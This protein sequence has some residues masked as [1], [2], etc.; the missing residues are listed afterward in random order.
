MVDEKLRVCTACGTA[1]PEKDY[2]VWLT[3]AEAKRY[4]YT[5]ERRV[6]VERSRCGDCRPKK[7]PLG[8]L[9][10]K[11][12]HK[13]VL[14]GDVHT[15]VAEAVIA[16]K[17]ANALEKQTNAQYKR[18]AAVKEKPWRDVL[19]SLAIELRTNQQRLTY[20]KK[21]ADPSP[22]LLA[23]LTRYTELLI[24]KREQMKTERFKLSRA[25]ETW[26]EYFSSSERHE[27]WQMWR[28]TPMV[29]RV[30]GGVPKLWD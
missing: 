13:R 19:A 24:V 20:A 11:Q 29:H 12:I 4:G 23:F 21:K 3:R 6:E 15:T 22:E 18:W 5:G 26:Q 16:K 7:K 1:K 17:K 10:E 9:S 27:L 14:S 30:N 2:L 25:P 28:D 8:R